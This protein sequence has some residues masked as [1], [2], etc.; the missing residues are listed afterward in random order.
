MVRELNRH[1]RFEALVLPHLDAAYNLA[2]W[3]TRSEHDSGDVVQEACLRAYA[4][5]DSFVGHDARPWLLA[6]TRNCAYSW[7]RKYR[8]HECDTPLDEGPMEPVDTGA[9]PAQILARRADAETV[10]HALDQLPVEFREVILLREM[11]GLS[12]REIAEVSGLPMGTVMSRL[13]R[14]RTK[15]AKI[16]REDPNFEGGQS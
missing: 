13:G 3:L 7:L 4:A 5:M 8:V 10:R 15:L 12:Y 9:D 14:A 16:L 6:I 1:E 2:R 11:E